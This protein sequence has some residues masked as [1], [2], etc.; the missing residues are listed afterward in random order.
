MT[1]GFLEVALS[2]SF[3]LTAIPDSNLLA[4]P[5]EDGLYLGR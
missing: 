1:E 3:V 5:P 2:G 4:F